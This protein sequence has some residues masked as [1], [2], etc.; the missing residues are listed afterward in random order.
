MRRRLGGAASDIFAL[1]TG[2]TLKNWVKLISATPLAA[3]G[4]P[5]ADAGVGNMR[6][7]QTKR[8]VDAVRALHVFS[9]K[10]FRELHAKP[11]AAVPRIHQY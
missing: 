2:K 3:A 11:G 7:I 6:H 9:W 4:C 1:V 10:A 5:P 8:M